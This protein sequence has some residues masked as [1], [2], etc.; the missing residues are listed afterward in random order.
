MDD[1]RSLLT[2]IDSKWNCN[3]HPH[4]RPNRSHGWFVLVLVLGHIATE[5]IGDD[6]PY[7]IGFGDDVHFNQVNGNGAQIHLLQDSFEGGTY[8]TS[9][10]YPL[11]AWD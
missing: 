8:T 9:I 10:S 11:Q 5:M 2:R 4:F 1:P 6:R 3:L 7:F